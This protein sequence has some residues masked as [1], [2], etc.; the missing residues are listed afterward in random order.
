MAL[1]YGRRRI[2]VALSDPTRTIASPR[3]VIERKARSGAAGG[4]LPA[5]LTRLVEETRPS[6][7]VV[8]IPL[9]MDGSAGEMAREARAFAAAVRDATGIP[10]AEWDERLTTSLAEREIRTMERKKSRRREKGRTDQVA[11]ALILS[12][13]LRRERGA[14]P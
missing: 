12:A 14:Q 9:A 8:G 1:D 2:G 3:G 13:F 11:A 10:T 7:I 4:A 6:L 5:A